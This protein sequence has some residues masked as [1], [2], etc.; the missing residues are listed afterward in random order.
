MS[1]FKRLFIAEKPAVAQCIV[2]ALGGDIQGNRASVGWAVGGDLIVNFFGHMLELKEPHDYNPNHEKWNI[3]DL[4]IINVPWEYKPRNDANVQRILK[5][6]ESHFKD[7]PEVVNAGDWDDQGQYLVDAV[8]DYY[9]YKGKTSRIKITSDSVADCQEALL[10]LEDNSKYRY[11]SN[12]AMST[13]VADQMYGINMT[14]LM[15]EQARKQGYT[16]PSL[17]TGRVMTPIVWLLYMRNKA[18]SGHV[19][20]FFYRVKGNFDFNGKILGL[21]YLPSDSDPVDEKSRL[22]LENRAQEVESQ[23][24]GKPVSVISNEIKQ[25]KKNAPRP[26]SI[27]DLHADAARTHKIPSKTVD[28][29]TQALRDKYDCITYNRTDNSYL[30]DSHFTEAKDTL[31]GLSQYSDWKLHSL[32]KGADTSIKHAAFNSDKTTAHHGIIPKSPVDPSNLTENERAVYELIVTRYVSLFYP[33]QIKKTTSI[34]VDCDGHSFGGKHTAIESPGWTVVVSNEE[35]VDDDNVDCPLSEIPKGTTGNCIDANITKGETTPPKAYTEDALMADLR[36]ASKYCSEET[37]ALLLKR[38]EDKDDD[39]KGGIGT[40]ATRASMLEK[41]LELGFGSRTEKLVW[42]ITPAGKQYIEILDD[43]LSTPDLTAL[44][45]SKQEGIIDG[46]LSVSDFISD[47][48][49]FIRK[50]V[51]KV[52]TQ[53]LELDIH[54]EPCD[55][56]GCNGI[57]RPVNGRNGVFFGCSNHSEGCKNTWAEKGGLPDKTP[58]RARRSGSSRSSSGR[59]STRAGRSERSGR[60]RRR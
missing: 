16:G 14:R 53:G 1:K 55:Q 46:D 52:K 21:H 39:E 17:N 19:K 56:E 37:K 48:A 11:W 45:F 2:E 27:A 31:N 54:S 38:D 59:S 10:N 4:P 49:D 40:P 51:E 23:V 26:Y 36:Q 6:C 41:I 58:R 34:I 29:I 43:E 18:R 5:Y 8:L 9:G 33:P 44:W 47:I 60:S 25:S 28:E 32:I 35:E 15:T 30:E 50:E 20:S 12:L 3:D 22:I 7:I 13:A 42:D 24:K 57:M